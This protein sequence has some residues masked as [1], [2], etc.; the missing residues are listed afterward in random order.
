MDESSTPTGNGAFPEKQ[1]GRQQA[2][3]PAHSNLHIKKRQTF[4][5]VNQV[6]SRLVNKLG[7]DQRLKE[8]ALLDLWATVAGNP[9][10][11]RSRPLFLDSQGNLVIAVK[12]A[13]TGQELSLMK[14]D[15]LQKLRPFARAI[16]ITVNGIRFDLKHFHGIRP[17]DAP[18]APPKIAVAQP[19]DDELAQISLTCEDLEQLSELRARLE[20]DAATTVDICNRIIFVYEREQRLK[21]WR[22][23][24]GFPLCFKCGEPGESFHGR[25]NVCKDCY[26]ESM[27]HKSDI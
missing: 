19:T 24:S 18:P 8:H 16:G 2:A 10:A 3:E 9:M 1:S 17:V 23:A 22:R 26:F 27:S 11:Q 15:L 20:S 25:E 6:L 14:V 13:P 21:H 4:T 12:D 7:L 5:S